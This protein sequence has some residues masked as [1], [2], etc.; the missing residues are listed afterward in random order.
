L[1]TVPVPA[2][3]PSSCRSLFDIGQLLS[4]VFRASLT[5]VLVLVVTRPA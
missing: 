1:T 2:R 5:L 3:A 4:F